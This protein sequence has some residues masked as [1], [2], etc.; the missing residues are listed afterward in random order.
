MLHHYGVVSTQQMTQHPTQDVL[1][2]PKLYGTSNRYDC[3]IPPLYDLRPRRSPQALHLA[4]PGPDSSVGR[5]P[6]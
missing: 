4:E 2:G 3:N 1:A 6:H 5:A